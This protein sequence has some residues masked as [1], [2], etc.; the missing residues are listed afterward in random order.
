MLDWNDKKIVFLENI[1]ARRA[2]VWN[3]VFE[4]DN[5]EKFNNLCEKESMLSKIIDRLCDE[6]PAVEKWIEDNKFLY[7]VEH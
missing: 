4:A 7:A 1:L 3:Q 6:D 2:L 5:M